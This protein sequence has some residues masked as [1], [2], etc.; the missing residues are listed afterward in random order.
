MCDFDDVI[1]NNKIV[2]LANKFLG[3]NYT[4]EDVGEGYDFSNLVTDKDKAREVCEYV[5]ENNFYIGATLKPN[6]YNVLKELQEKYGYEIY[7]C[8]ACIVTGYED[9]SG[10]VF[11]N[12]FDYICKALPFVN[13]KNIIFTNAKGVV[14]GDVMIDDRLTNLNGDFETKILFDCWYNRKFGADELKARGV[15]RAH[16][17]LEIKDILI[18]K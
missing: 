10:V 11:K 1:C 14:G 17:W 5:L 13:P 7:I 6:C 15:H 18:N 12:K 9:M 2:A 4:F 16:D 8:S 3:T